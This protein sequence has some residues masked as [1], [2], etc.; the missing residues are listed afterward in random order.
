MVTPLEAIMRQKIRFI[1]AACLAGVTILLY[2]AG[3]HHDITLAK[4]Q[5]HSLRLYQFVH[6]HYLVSVSAYV[7]MFIV[8]TVN[9]HTNYHCTDH[10]RGLFVWFHCRGILGACR[11]SKREH[12]AIFYN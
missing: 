5:L 8:A 2:V 4:V 9:C 11:R 12:G 10:C 1:I 6:E 3:F 7:A